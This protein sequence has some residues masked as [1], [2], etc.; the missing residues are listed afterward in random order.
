MSPFQQRKR[1]MWRFRGLRAAVILGLLAIGLSC[2]V[3]SGPATAA[4]PGGGSAPPIEICFVR[5]ANSS[6]Q[7]RGVPLSGGNSTVIADPV[8][9]YGAPRWSP[10]GTRLLYMEGQSPNQSIVSVAANGS[11]KRIHL[12]L[13]ELDAFNVADGRPSFIAAAL[14]GWSGFDWGASWS[15][16]GNHITFQARTGYAYSPTFVPFRHRIYMMRLSDGAISRVT[17]G[18]DPFSDTEDVGPH[19]SPNLDVI[20]FA[21]LPFGGGGPNEIWAASPDGAW[22]RSLLTEEDGIHVPYYFEWSHGGDG[23]SKSFFALAS[24][25]VGYV[26]EVDYL[27]ATPVTGMWPISTPPGVDYLSWKP[28]DSALVMERTTNT[29]AQIVTFTFATGQEK[30]VIS[31]KK[32]NRFLFLNYPHWRF[33]P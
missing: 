15:P 16:D 29:H 26:V 19:W 2:L 14:Q 12:T 3:S 32:G 27:A 8:F 28:D 18:F 6:H 31:E 24:E 9:R 22:S 23:G 25:G 4:K 7:L 30:L 17:D 21:R 10:D 20:G 33:L 11:D 1:I 5:S 13:A